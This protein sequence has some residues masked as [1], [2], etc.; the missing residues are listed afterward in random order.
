MISNYLGHA[1]YVNLFNHLLFIYF[2]GV[3]FLF[4]FFIIGFIGQLRE[5]GFFYYGAV[6]HLSFPGIYH[7]T[8]PSSLVSPLSI[9][10][11]S[12][13]IIISYTHQLFLLHEH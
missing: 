11:F 12:V 13:T 9:V 10:F 6:G 8:P 4:L 7:P 1:V 5:L 2:Y 3:F